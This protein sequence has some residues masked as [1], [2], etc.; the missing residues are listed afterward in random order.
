LAGETPFW[1]P[2]EG[3]CATPFAAV[4]SAAEVGCA[5]QI[6]CGASQ[7]DSSVL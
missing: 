1:Q 3:A 5:T 4:R 2:G 6:V 7:L